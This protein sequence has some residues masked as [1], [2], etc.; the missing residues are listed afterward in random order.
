[1]LDPVIKNYALTSWCR[2]GDRFERCV[3]VEMKVRGWNKS[4]Q[5]KKRS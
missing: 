3:E 4:A 2:Y 5:K 1:M